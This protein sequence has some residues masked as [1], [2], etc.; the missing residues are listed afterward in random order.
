MSIIYPL[1]Y[2]LHVGLMLTVSKM[3]TFLSPLPVW[4]YSR[5]YSTGSF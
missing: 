3:F 5:E 2:L 4:E 1:N